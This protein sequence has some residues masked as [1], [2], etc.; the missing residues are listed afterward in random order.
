MGYNACRNAY[1]EEIVA[2]TYAGEDVYLVAADLA[3]PCLDKMREDYPHRY[4]PVGI[5]EQ[6]LIAVAS[7]LVLTGKK[8]IAYTGNPFLISRAYDQ[9]RNCVCSM[10]LP[11]AL[12]GLGAGFSQPDYGF[13][14]FILEDI[15]ILRGSTELTILNLSDVNLAK[16]AAQKTLNLTSPIYVR[17]DRLVDAEYNL[18]ENDIERGFRI[19]HNAADKKVCVVSTG[20]MSTEC[21]EVL[22]SSDEFSSNV[23]LI[24]VFSFPF[25]GKALVDELKKYQRIITVEEMRLQGGLGSAVLETLG[26]AGVY[27]PVQRMGIDISRGISPHYGS[28]EWHLKQFGLD[29]NSIAEKISSALKE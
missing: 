11:L 5:A 2:A 29:K 4:V 3:A 9:I 19:L 1:L 15:N 7:G 6:N 25:D 24:D 8:A 18:T 22:N 16:Y 12:V 26:D 14:H 23:G 21:F 27:I 17:I 13:T 20:I 10:H 28:R